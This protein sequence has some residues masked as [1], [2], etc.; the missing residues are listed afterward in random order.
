MI[1][2]GRPSVS[3]GGGPPRPAG[4][5]SRSTT[6][7]AQSANTDRVV[8]EDFTFTPSEITVSAG[9]TITWTNMDRAAN[10]A[11]SGDS[12]SPDGVFETDTIDGG[13]ETGSVKVK[14]RGTFSYFCL[15]HPLMRGTVT[16]R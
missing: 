15:F 8:I 7:G 11:T 4:R 16:V 12:P 2:P 6:G 9:T 1:V 10:T 5:P 14:R 3:G 13:G